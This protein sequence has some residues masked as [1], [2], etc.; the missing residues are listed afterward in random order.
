MCRC[1][2]S[3]ARSLGSALYVNTCVDRDASIW[4]WK[5][6]A[7]RLASKYIYAHTKTGAKNQSV[8]IKRIM[9]A[10]N[11]NIVG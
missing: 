1:Q 11:I 10:E 9:T 4:R 7:N 5:A 3:I 2:L 6:R 8:E